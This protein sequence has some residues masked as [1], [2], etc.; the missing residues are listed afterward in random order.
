MNTDRARQ[1]LGW[2]PRYDAYQTLWAT[3]A[4]AGKP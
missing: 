2:Q 1:Q 4:G 3:V